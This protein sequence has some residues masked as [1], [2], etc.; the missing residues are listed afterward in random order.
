MKLNQVKMQTFV[1]ICEK[2]K[3]TM[4]TAILPSRDLQLLILHLL[5]DGANP[6]FMQLPVRLSLLPS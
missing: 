1:Y 5:E 4:H 6:A 3:K 2:K